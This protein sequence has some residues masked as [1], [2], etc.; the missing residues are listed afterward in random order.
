MILLTGLQSFELLRQMLKTR[1]ITSIDLQRSHSRNLGATT[2][3][4]TGVPKYTFPS[5][6]I[7]SHSRL[8]R[9]SQLPDSPS[10][11]LFSVFEIFVPI[12]PFRYYPGRVIKDR[13]T[14]RVAPRISI[15]HRVE[16]GEVQLG[17]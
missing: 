15:G 16:L 11:H 4:L 10:L 14:R 12:F 3:M 2:C 5:L 7:S 17:K 8:F 9:S 6:I 13:K 1:S